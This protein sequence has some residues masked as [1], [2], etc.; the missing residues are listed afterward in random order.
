ME[1]VLH[2]DVSFGRGAIN[3]FGHDAKPKSRTRE[4]IRG[5]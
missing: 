5:A 1:L 3:T 2:F 4:H